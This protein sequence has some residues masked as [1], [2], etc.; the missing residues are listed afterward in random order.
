[1]VASRSQLGLP[2]QRSER[3]PTA[4]STSEVRLCS[5]DSPRDACRA[6]FL[7]AGE[8]TVPWK[9]PRWVLRPSAAW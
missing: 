1:M 7:S 4:G 9:W 5:G 3:I 6:H 8:P 2:T